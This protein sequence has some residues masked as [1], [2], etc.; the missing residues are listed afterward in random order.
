[1]TLPFTPPPTLPEGFTLSRCTPA[2]VP[3]VT[4]VYMDA[5]SNSEYTYWWGPIPAMWSWQE[6]RIRRR[7]TDPKT[8][9]FKVVDNENGMVVAWAKWETPP[10]MTGLAKGFVLYNEAGEPAG[11]GEDDGNEGGQRVE[12]FGEENARPNGSKYAMDPPEG[13]NSVLY[14]EFFNGLVEMGKKHRAGDKLVLTHLCTRHSYHGRGI[15]SA[16]LHSVLDIADREGIPA[17]LEA[18][19]VGQ[20]LYRRLGWAVVDTLEYNRRQSD[21][22]IPATLYIMVRHPRIT[23]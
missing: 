5:F 11:P 4:E 16:L 15:G 8:H 13:S 1:M 10:G 2:D 6:E 17:Y 19:R 7:F 18:S 23:G 22:S 20:P 9:Q 3:S 14:Q 21:T 12:E